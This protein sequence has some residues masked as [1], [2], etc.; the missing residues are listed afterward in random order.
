MLL[1]I[2]WRNIWRNPRRSLIVLGSVVVGVIAIIFMDALTIGFSR[3]MLFNQIDLN[4]GHIQIHKNGFAANKNIKSF[5]PDNIEVENTLRSTNGIKNWSKRV[6]AFGLLSSASNSAG[7]YI[8]GVNA[9]DEKKISVIDESIKKGEFL[10]GGVREIVIGQKLADK[11]GVEL[12]DKVVGMSNRVDGSIGSEVFRIKGIFSTSNSE[13]DKA[14][15]YTNIVTIQSMLDLGDKVY[16]YGITTNDYNEASKISTLLSN[17]LNSQYEVLS[18]N[19][20]LP[21]LILQIDMT[22]QSMIVVNIII[23]LALIFGIINTMLMTVYERI[24][25]FGVLMSIGMK[26][27]KLFIMIVLEAFIIGT[28]GAALGLILGSALVYPFSVG[29][30]DMSI[31]AEGLNS[32][33]TGA[34]IYP[35]LNLDG[36]LNTVIMIPFITVLGAV[37][38][39]IKAIRLEPVNAIRYV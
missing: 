10:S 22:K 3:Q 4:V 27:R 23:G 20:I 14:Y 12:G 35:V 8:Y 17:K 38:P 7:I 19:D 25:E 18:Y 34:V 15:V 33:G 32:L 36:I 21:L 31:F 39:A 11:L 24:R 16:E 6:I 28:F 30:I 26:N 37:Y 9:E 13:F 5:I 1:K 2:A 29:G